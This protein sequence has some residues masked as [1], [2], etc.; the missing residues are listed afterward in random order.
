M[1]ENMITDRTAED[2]LRW[3]ELRDKGIDKMTPAELE[4]WESNMKGSYN[5]SDLNRVGS[6]L[7]F[8]RNELIK[9]GYLVGIEFNP[10]TDWKE[11]DVP[12]R[13]E[14]VW[15][16][17]A[18]GVVRDA[19]ARY[20]TT[21]KAPTTNSKLDFQIANDIEQILIDVDDLLIKTN[22]TPLYCGELYCGEI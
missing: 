17:Y 4:E 16:V 1:L 22:A 20:R 7:A 12:T 6:A 5:I 2:V 9:A 13:Q 18:V 14:Y 11:N 8:L 21:P 15:I 19:L 3:R 10:K